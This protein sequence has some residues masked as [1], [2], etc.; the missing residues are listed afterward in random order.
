VQLDELPVVPWPPV[1][2][3][4]DPE[5]V[6]LPQASAADAKHARRIERAKRMDPS[7]Q[8]LR[9]RS[10]AARAAGTS[11]SPLV[12]GP[13]FTYQRDIGQA[14]AWGSS[15]WKAGEGAAP[16]RTS[17]GRPR[18]AGAGLSRDALAPG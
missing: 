2:P 1:P 12:R 10:P 16:P 5:G 15:G 9:E 6:E 11:A 18:C 14:S 13:M 4:V 17:R 3:V 8:G 7:S